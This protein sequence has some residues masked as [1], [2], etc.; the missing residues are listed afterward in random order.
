LPT[1]QL[2]PDRKTLIVYWYLCSGR[3]G[4]SGA[5]AVQ[6]ALGFSSPSTAVFH[7]ERLVE[8]GLVKKARDGRYEV[9][10]YRKFGLMT[11]FLHFGSWWIPK[12]LAY[13]IVTTTIIFVVLLLLF[14]IFGWL[15][16]LTLIPSALSA[17]IQWYEALTLL[18]RRP[19][20]HKDTTR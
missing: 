13:A 7:L 19:T 6:R 10:Q 15:T 1:R 16:T 5:R 17:F 20:F 8:M 9:I 18:R 11:R 3:H 4:E 2:I 12:H 14:P